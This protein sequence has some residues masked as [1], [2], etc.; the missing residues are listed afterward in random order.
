MVEWASSESERT[1]DQSAA[2][3]RKESFVTDAAICT[4]GCEPTEADILLLK[5]PLWPVA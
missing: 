2:I 4:K 5:Q 1:F 3:G